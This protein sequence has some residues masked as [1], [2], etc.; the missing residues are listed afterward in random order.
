MSL[1]FPSKA[2]FPW[3]EMSKY[4]IL[5]P[6]VFLMF[7]Q[8]QIESCPVLLSMGWLDGVGSCR[9][10]RCWSGPTSTHENRPA[11]KEKKTKSDQQKKKK[12]KEKSFFY[13]F[14]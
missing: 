9:V 11:V 7:H 13:L 3:N 4:R 1:D 5:F 10:G 14:I 2:T 8:V 6:C 12:K